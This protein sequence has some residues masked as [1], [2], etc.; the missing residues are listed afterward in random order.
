MVDTSLLYSNILKPN[1]LGFTN[2][3]LTCSKMNAILISVPISCLI[4]IRTLSSS[5]LSCFEEQQ[6]L[7]QRL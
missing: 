4:S 1:Q 2:P 7:A 3:I 6:V 5:G